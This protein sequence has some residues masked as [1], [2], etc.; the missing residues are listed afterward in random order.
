[1]GLTNE[2]I[3]ATSVGDYTH[4][5]VLISMPRNCDDAR[6]ANLHPAGDEVD[7]SSY[8]RGHIAGTVGWNLHRQLQNVVRRDILDSA[9]FKAVRRFGLRMRRLPALAIFGICFMPLSAVSQEPPPAQ[10]RPMHSST[11]PFQLQALNPGFWNLISHDAKLRVLATGFGFTEGPVWDERGFLYVSDE[12]QNKIYRVDANGKKTAI[13]SLGIPDGN[14]YDRRGQFVDCA[15]VLRAVIRINL[16]DGTYTTLAHLYDGKPLDAPN[17]IVLGPDGALYFTD[18]T[19]ALGRA[20][21]EGFGVMPPT[22]PSTGVYR[23]SPDGHLTKLAYRSKQ[24]NGLAFSP[25]GKLLYVNDTV[26]GNIRVFDFHDGEIS[27]GRIFGDEPREPGKPGV[28]DGMKMDQ[29]GDVWVS[30]PGGIWVWSPAG[31]HLGTIQFPHGATNFSWGGPGFET[32]YVAASDTV[33]VLPTLVRG[34]VPYYQHY[35]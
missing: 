28:P 35:H 15:T 22:Q 25:D 2:E 6:D 33:Y 14:T 3:K 19:L 26:E 8:N 29:R 10:R 12:V 11:L 20:P 18:D 21:G 30:G 16:K 31:Q 5:E 17:D 23:L 24:P 9:Q 32:L 34:F 13:V 4:P 1:M 27:N 7:T